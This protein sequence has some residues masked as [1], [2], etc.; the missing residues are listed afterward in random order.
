[1]VSDAKQRAKE[2]VRGVWI[3]IPTPF[4]GEDLHIDEEALRVS[5]EYY[6]D[7]LKVDGIFC[8]GVM[9]EFWSLTMPERKRAH[10]LVVETAAGRVPIMPHVGA[11]VF[12]DMVELTR[13]AEEIGADFG[14]SMNPYYPVKLGDD[15]VRAWYRELDRRTS[16][17]M[18]LFNTQY[19]GYSMS[20]E[21]ISELADLDT[22]CGIKN[23]GPREHLLRVQE[24]TGDRLVVAD[25]GEEEW[26]ELHLEHG[27]QALMSTPELALYQ[28]RGHTPVADYTRLADDGEVEAA[29]KLQGTLTEERALAAT[30]IKTSYKERGIV[31]IAALKAWLTNMGLP[32]GPVRLPLL[33]LT[34]D[35]QDS[36]RGQM[37]A[38][39]LLDVTN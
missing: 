31:P 32:Q 24:L 28:Y 30:W 26:L 4:A 27:L 2:Q 7:A 36:L 12:E 11:H 34:D 3:A 19:S 15:A 1:M 38:L 14:I 8:G 25:A 9:G 29:W 23:P 35:E 6:I 33:Q 37:D 20:P 22:I 18:F 5:V 17:P 39:G 16:L 21:L 13:H 10:E